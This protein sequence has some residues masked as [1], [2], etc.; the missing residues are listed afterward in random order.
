MYWLS[1]THKGFQWHNTQSQKAAYTVLGTG[2]FSVAH[3]CCPADQLMGLSFLSKLLFN[4][5][6]KYMM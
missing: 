5:F 6:L 2:K 4:T 1:N 3:Y